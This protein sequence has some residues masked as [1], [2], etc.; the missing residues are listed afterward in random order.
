M[1][2]TEF[3][4]PERCNYAAAVC[5]FGVERVFYRNLEAPQDLFF[6][7]WCLRQALLRQFQC[8]GLMIPE[9]RW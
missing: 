5:S 9:L 3:L 2:Y 6:P 8:P 4:H 1:T 7:F